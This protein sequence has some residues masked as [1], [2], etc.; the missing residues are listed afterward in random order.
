MYL[1]WTFSV[2]KYSLAFQKDEGADFELSANTRDCKLNHLLVHALKTQGFSVSNSSSFSFGKFEISQIR[3]KSSCC[4][5]VRLLQ[6]DGQGPKW[7]VG[8]GRAAQGSAYHGLLP[9]R[10]PTRRCFQT[11]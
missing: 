1:R 11:L 4:S 5:S 8:S 9:H 10:R 7:E 3:I 2:I 6:N